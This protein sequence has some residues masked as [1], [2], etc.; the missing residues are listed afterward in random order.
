[1][2]VEIHVDDYVDYLTIDGLTK[3]SGVDKEYHI[4]LAVKE[5]VD[6]A[7]DAAGKCILKRNGQNSFYVEDKGSGI[8]G[9]DE[10]IAYLFS[11]DRKTYS[12]KGERYPRRGYMGRGLRFVSGVAF[13]HSANLK[14]STGGRTLLLKPQVRGTMHERIME[15]NDNFNGT[16]ISVE[17]PMPLPSNALNW[18]KL[19]IKLAK[20]P[21]YKYFS[22]PFW[23]ESRSFYVLLKSI[24]YNNKKIINVLKEVFGGRYSIKVFDEKSQR[25]LKQTKADGITVED[26][27]LILEELKRIH[28]PI[29]PSRLGYVGKLKEFKYYIKEMGEYEDVFKQGGETESINIPYVI[30][31]WAQPTNN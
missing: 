24:S 11:V 6:N 26:A 18:G 29:K 15:D 8:P 16:T 2:G 20:G 19:A 30:E 22:S 10:E 1:M 4:A 13:C 27:Q 31:L 21:D 14:V 7:L 3:V 9:E 28:K 12:T 17:F 5:L 23:Y 25:L